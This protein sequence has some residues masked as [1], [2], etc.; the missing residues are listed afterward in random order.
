MKKHFIYITIGI[1]VL[2]MGAIANAQAY[3]SATITA[4]RVATTSPVDAKAA[5]KAKLQ[6]V[7]TKLE[8]S[9]EVRIMNLDS[10]ATRIQTRIT[11]IQAKGGDMTTASAKLAEAQKA[12]AEAKTELA[13]LRKADVAMIASA[14]PATAFATIKKKTAKNVVVKIKAAHKALVDTIVIM[15]GQGVPV[16]ATSTAR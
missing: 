2:G 9:L 12:I 15:K 8:G 14:K 5:K 11:K 13:N 4:P 10:L 6:E 3:P 16:S 1:A 7:V